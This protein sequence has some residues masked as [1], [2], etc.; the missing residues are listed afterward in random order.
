MFNESKRMF[1][2]SVMHDAGYYLGLTWVASQGPKW[3]HA[4]DSVC[5]QSHNDLQL[6]YEARLASL[7]VGPEETGFVSVVCRLKSKQLGKGPAGLASIP[8]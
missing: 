8:M 6:A 5:V 7:G 4:G 1:Y 2:N 3:D